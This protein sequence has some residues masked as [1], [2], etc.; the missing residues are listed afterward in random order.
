M[1]F[2]IIHHSISRLEPFAEKFS[3]AAVDSGTIELQKDVGR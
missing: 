1:L 2:K 3:W